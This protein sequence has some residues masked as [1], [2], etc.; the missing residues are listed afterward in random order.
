MLPSVLVRFGAGE[1]A[2]E[3]LESNDLPARKGQLGHG[4]LMLVGVNELDLAVLANSNTWLRS[5]DPSA[6]DALP[7]FHVVI[8]CDSTAANP[9]PI[10]VHTLAPSSRR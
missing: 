10:D 1:P 3:C 2:N 7:G 4:L 6:A 8:H 9:F 5:L